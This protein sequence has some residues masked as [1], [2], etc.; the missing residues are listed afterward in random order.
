MHQSKIDVSLLQTA[1]IRPTL[2]RKLILFLI[3]CFSAIWAIDASSGMLVLFDQFSY[4]ICIF[5]FSGIY[6][7]SATNRVKNTIL[8]M[9]AYTIIASFLIGSSIWSHASGQGISLNSLQ[10][11]GLNYVMAC[12]FLEIKKAVPT[13]VAVFAV[14]IIGHFIVLIPNFPLRDT[15][16]VILNIAV[17]HIAYIAL[18]WTVVKLR[19][20]NEKALQ[21]AME[22]ETYANVDLLTHILNRRGIDKIFKELGLNSDEN[23]QVYSILVIDIDH[24]KHVNDQ[25]GHLI[26]DQVL[27]KIASHLS[28]KIHP[29]DVLGRWGG[30][31][32]LILT[33]ENDSTKVLELAERLRDTLSQLDI[34]PVLSITAS[35]GIGYSDEG[36]TTN[37]VF[38][39]ADNNLYT[40]KNIGRNRIIDSQLAK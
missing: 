2:L 6:I 16:D 9:L 30:E 31:E 24:F 38:K 5:A 1:A 29:N 36:K 11:L 25:H 33:L 40:A 7:L 37:D 18:L 34:T 4:P 10:W 12:L 39:I 35:I 15:L 32:F 21:Q 8:L 17:A 20:N 26:G 19:V 14:T 22:F 13:A 27:R 3:I 23:Q 28:R